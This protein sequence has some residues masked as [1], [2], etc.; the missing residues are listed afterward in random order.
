MFQQI[1]EIMKNT[2]P[3]CDPA[4]YCVDPAEV[5]IFTMPGFRYGR[6][7]SKLRMQ[8]RSKGYYITVIK[9]SP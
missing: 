7:S 3:G 4:R 6:F 1:H 2:L 9:A 5:R 8:R